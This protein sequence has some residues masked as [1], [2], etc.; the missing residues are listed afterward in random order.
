MPAILMTRSHREHTE[1]AHALVLLRARRERGVI[2]GPNVMVL[3]PS[4]QAKTAPDFIV[5][6][7]ANPRK[8]NMASSGNGCTPN[9][10]GELFKMMTGVDMVHVPY[11]AA[12]PALTDLLGGHVPVMFSTMS[13]SIECIRA[14]TLPALTRT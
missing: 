7:K 4:V 10:A 9:V 11:R 8:V 5:R 13:S 3:H 1:A 12:A 14:A 6:A 2:R